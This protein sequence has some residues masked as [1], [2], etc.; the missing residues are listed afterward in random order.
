MERILREVRDQGIS[1]VELDRAKAYLIG[2]YEID[3]QAPLAMASTMA[4]DERYGLGGDFYQRYPRQIEQ[5]TTEDVLRV[6]RKYIALDSS[7]MVIV[8]PA[9]P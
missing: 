7:S 3:H 4:F 2:N 9:T 5:V 6:A 8:R 1:Q